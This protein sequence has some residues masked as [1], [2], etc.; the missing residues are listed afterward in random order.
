MF[1]NYI[2]NIAKYMSGNTLASVSYRGTNEKNLDKNYSTIIT[3]I[4]NINSY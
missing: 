1:T 2:L 3:E 4:M